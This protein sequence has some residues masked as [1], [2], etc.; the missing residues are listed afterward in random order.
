MIPENRKEE[1]LILTMPVMNNIVQ[2]NLRKL[3]GW[4][5]KKSIERN[6]AEKYRNELRIATPSIDK[7]VMYLSGGNQQKVVLAKWLCTEGEIFIFDEP[8]AESTSAQ[9]RKYTKS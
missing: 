2:A 8:T 4:F 9:R 7:M 1:G 5:I 3:F 6:I